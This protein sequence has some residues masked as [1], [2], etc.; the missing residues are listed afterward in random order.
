MAKKT[1]RKSAFV[2]STTAFFSQS[3]RSIYQCI[4]DSHST[5]KA[6][7]TLQIVIMPCKYSKLQD[8]NNNAVTCKD[9]HTDNDHKKWDTGNGFAVWCTQ[10]G[11]QTVCAGTL[12]KDQVESLECKKKA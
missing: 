3:L 7:S 12:R 2:T 1:D 8:P 9:S 5:S 4:D 10:C 6:L 11:T